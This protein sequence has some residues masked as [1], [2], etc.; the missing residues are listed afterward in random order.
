MALIFL[1]LLLFNKTIILQPLEIVQSNSSV[2]NSITYTITE[3]PTQYQVPLVY[4]KQSKS[5]TVFPVQIHKDFTDTLDYDLDEFIDK[6]NECLDEPRVK[7]KSSD[8]TSSGKYIEPVFGTEID[9]DKL[10]QYIKENYTR[11][12]TI[13]VTQFYVQPD[14]TLDKEYKKLSEDIQNFHVTWS[15]G[16]T[17]TKEDCNLTVSND[18]IHINI[19]E[20]KLN[21]CVATIVNTYDTVGNFSTEYKTYSGDIKQV[22]GGT[23]GNIA[24]TKAEE[25]WVIQQALSLNAVDN[26][27]PTMKQEMPDTLPSKRIEVDLTNQHVRYLNGDTIIS[28]SDCVTGRARDRATPTGVYYIS[29]KIKEKDLKGPGYVSHVHRWMRLTNS[30]VGLHDATWRSSFGGNI[31]ISNGSHG[32]INLPKAYAYELYDTVDVETCVVIFE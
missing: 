26:R 27:H 32:C 8:I 28:E 18:K 1:Y 24:D 12:Q 15:N 2:Q 19:D 23:W 22:H 4:E 17:V 11:K 3:G 13:D 7:S 29:E 31:Y 9:S 20:D 16:K 21:K 25:D 10:N 30:G 14:L 5:N 6:I